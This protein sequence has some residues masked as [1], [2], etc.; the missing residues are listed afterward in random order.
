MGIVIGSLILY[1]VVVIY[2]A[3]SAKRQ[4]RASKIKMYQVNDK[5]GMVVEA[6]SQLDAWI[7][8]VELYSS[9]GMKEPKYEDIKEVA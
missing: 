1:V 6:R 3:V 5:F 7:Q 4:M 9:R 8:V 2:L